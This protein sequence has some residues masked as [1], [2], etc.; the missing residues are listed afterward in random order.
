MID[1]Y[2][3]LHT[4]THHLSSHNNNV[5]RSKQKVHQLNSVQR[6]KQKFHQLSNVQRPKQ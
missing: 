1:L 6:S 5:Q 4:H 2:N 3:I